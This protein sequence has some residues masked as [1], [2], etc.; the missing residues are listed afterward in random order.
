MENKFTEDIRD[1]VENENKEMEKIINN[2]NE[3]EKNEQIRE[4]KIEEF[5]EILDPI[6]SAFDEE[7]KKDEFFR[8]DNLNSLVLLNENKNTM[9]EVLNILLIKLI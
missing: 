3:H 9:L 5:Q 7:T 8:D 4:L 2:E 1:E 6:K